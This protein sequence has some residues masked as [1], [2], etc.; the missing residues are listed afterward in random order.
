M[1][2]KKSQSILEYAILIAIIV[3]AILIMQTFMKRG[4]QGRLKDSSEKISGGENYSASETTILEERAMQTGS[5]RQIHEMTGTDGST[6]TMGTAMGLGEGFTG[7][8]TD[9]TS[10]S[11]YTA[12]AVTG[13]DTTSKTLNK[14]S[15]LTQ[16]N[17]T[18]AE[19]DTT[20]NEVDDFGESVSTA[21][22]T[23]ADDEKFWKESE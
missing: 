7:N 9:V 18:Q 4:V 14:T 6:A 10:N 16:E 15:S 19:Y 21:V 1:L 23:K 22:E 5:D 3:A 8:I 17:Y 11:A 20:K 12:T 13:G 2:Y